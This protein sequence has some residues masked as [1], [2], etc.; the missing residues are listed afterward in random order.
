MSAR[1]LAASS[2]WLTRPEISTSLNA[3]M[4]FVAR[5]DG[6][7]SGRVRLLMRETMCVSSFVARY[8]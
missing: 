8:L 1:A 7:T 2:G 6:R 5:V 3:V 4:L